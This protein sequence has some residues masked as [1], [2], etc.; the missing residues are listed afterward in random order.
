M[1]ET[2]A[3]KRNTVVDFFTFKNEYWGCLSSCAPSGCPPE[4]IFAEIM[5]VIRGSRVCARNL[6]PLDREEYVL[7]GS[8]V[9][10]AFP[11]VDDRKKAFEVYERYE[12]LKKQRGQIDDLDRV[13]DVLKFI[14]ETPSFA[15]QL[16]G[17]FEEIY[18][19][20]I[21]DLRC[22]DVALLFKAV[23]NARGVHLG[24]LPFLA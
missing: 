8:K 14:A 6:Q 7:K 3:L 9:S 23:F 4:L 18:V 1:E 2:G 15:S 10:P 11:G 20:E 16:R 5:G 21:Q 22:V 12:K 24:N 19:D 17:C 13:M